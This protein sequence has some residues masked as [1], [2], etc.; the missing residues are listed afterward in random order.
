MS[1]SRRKNGILRMINYTH[2]ASPDRLEKS[3]A[4]VTGTN[5][6]TSELILTNFLDIEDT[7]G[8]LSALEGR[9]NNEELSGRLFKHGVISFGDPHL[10]AD[11]AK[12]LLKETLDYYKEFPWLAALHTDKPHRLHAH[13]LLLMRNVLTGKKFSQ[14]VADLKDFRRHYHH[15]ALRFDLLG[16]KDFSD[17]PTVPSTTDEIDDYS[18]PWTNANAMAVACSQFNAGYPYSAYDVQAYQST[19]PMASTNSLEGIN[20]LFKTAQAGINDFFT[21]GFLEGV[22]KND[23]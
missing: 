16:L 22:S 18:F 5:K 21:I 23:Q 3:I 13:F 9:W 10:E 15:L 8:S 11:K 19:F 17:P 6:T 12:E 14:S 7:M 20:H 1:D 4:Y 2:G